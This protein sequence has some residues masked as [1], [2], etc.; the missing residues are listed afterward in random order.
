MVLLSV[1]MDFVNGRYY[2]GT[3]ASLLSCSRASIGYAKNADGT[4]TQFGNDTLRI[5][6]G[7]GL[8]VEDARTN[9]VLMEQ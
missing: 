2:G 6:V 8:L 9:V 7:T 3:T 5:S 1:D 4:L